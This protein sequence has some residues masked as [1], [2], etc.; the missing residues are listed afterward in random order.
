MIVYC[1]I[2][3]EFFL[4]YRFAKAGDNVCV[5]ES[6][7]EDGRGDN[8]TNEL[9][10]VKVLWVHIRRGGYLDGIVVV[11]RVLE[12]AVRWIEHPM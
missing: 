10:V 11:C 8:P 3:L 1:V 12:Q 6:T 2:E 7:I 5:E 9:E 4:K